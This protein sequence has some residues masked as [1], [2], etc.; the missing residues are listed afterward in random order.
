[1]RVLKAA[2]TAMVSAAVVSLIAGCSGS[3]SSIQS[4]TPHPSMHSAS[5]LDGTGVAPKYLSLLRFNIAAPRIVPNSLT[6]PK[7]LAVSDFGT[8][9][10]EVLNST[11][12]LKKTI[13]TGLN[14]PDGDW[15]DQ[16]GN[17]YVANYA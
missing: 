1:M 4:I 9:A 16:L 3:G 12:A 6:P 8:G 17:L 10:V 14:G 7:R 2:L 5:H 11:Y 13:T 15:Y